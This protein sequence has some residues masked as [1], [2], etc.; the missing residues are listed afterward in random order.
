MKNTSVNTE[1]AWKRLGDEVTRRG[2][3]GDA[4]V[5]A[6]KD[7]YSIYTPDL[8]RWAG[9][10]FDYE[11]GGFYFSNSA[12]DVRV[13]E[14]RGKTYHFRPDVESTMQCINF[15]YAV[16]AVNAPEDFPE[17]FRNK[18]RDFVSSLQDPEDG[19][20]YHPQWERESI[21]PSRLARDMHWAIGLATKLGFSLPYPTAHD[22]IKAAVE[23]K[24][25]EKESGIPENFRSRE[26]FLE[27]ISSLNWQGS[28]TTGAYGAGN[29][30]AAESKLIEAAGLTDVAV[31]FLNSVQN[32]ENGL[33]GDA[34]G[35]DGNN[36]FMKI[37]AFY[38][39][40]KRPIPNATKAI[41]NALSCLVTDEFARTSCYNFN[42]WYS[43]L[44]V[45]AN[46]RRFGGEEGAREASAISDMLL[47]DAP[48]YLKG[49]KEK[50]L[51]FRKPDGS[52]SCLTTSTTPI[53]Q[54][55]PVA[56]EGTNEGDF[57]ALALN[58]SGTF[59]RIYACLGLSDFFVP[60]FSENSLEIFLSAIKKN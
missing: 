5:A 8:L 25:D 19:F 48:K 54:G 50:I 1:S 58:S 15:L 35:Y 56:V 59:V 6:M 4:F 28:G 42:V 33:W 3:D 14:Y 10:L 31:E 37:S 60:P 30:I 16:R 38:D 40:V 12:R 26:A 36:A 52:F 17:W 46:L 41:K 18:V 47:L 49:T 34:E 2:G 29:R 23:N 32:P 11:I 21:T 20:I 53:S 22:R 7:Y 43:I 55:M 9:A 57:N 39:A 27:Y 24:K 51:T 45:I 13:A 44:N